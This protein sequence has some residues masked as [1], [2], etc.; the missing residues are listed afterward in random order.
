MAADALLVKLA[1]LLA[2]K[3]DR[4]DK[5]K[6]IAEMIR[7]EGER[8]GG[9]VFTMSILTRE[10]FQILPGAVQVPQHIQHSLSRRV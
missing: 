5:A 1:V 3:G 9:Q 8:T 7:A 6:T 2:Q 4:S 10:S